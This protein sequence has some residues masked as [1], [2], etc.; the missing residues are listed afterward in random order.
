MAQILIFIL[1]TLSLDANDVFKVKSF[2]ELK[3]TELIDKQFWLHRKELIFF[4]YTSK[5]KKTNHYT[6]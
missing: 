1:L 3:Y 5:T 6:I 2:K 4:C